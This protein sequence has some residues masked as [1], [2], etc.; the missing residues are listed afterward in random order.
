MSLELESSLIVS[1][2]QAIGTYKRDGKEISIEGVEE[3]ILLAAN[4][5][6]A[7]SSIT[8]RLGNSDIKTALKPVSLWAISNTNNYNIQINSTGF[9]TTV[10]SSLIGNGYKFPEFIIDK[11]KD[12][13]VIPSALISRLLI[14]C[15]PVSLLQSFVPNVIT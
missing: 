5:I 9:N 15:K 6:A 7:N 4:N 14:Y 11:D 13:I 12:I 10:A 8:W 3:W 2:S 1:G